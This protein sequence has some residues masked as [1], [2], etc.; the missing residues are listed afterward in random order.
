MEEIINM[1]NK[2]E[3]ADLKDKIENIQIGQGVYIKGLGIVREAQQKYDRDLES[4]GN[5]MKVMSEEI[6]K[7]KEIIGVKET[8]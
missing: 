3:I 1:T 4:M 5:A 7:L 6:G 2:E 8:K